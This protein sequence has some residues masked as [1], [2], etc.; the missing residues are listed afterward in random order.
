MIE[1]YAAVFDAMR[2]REYGTG[3]P[4]NGSKW[5]RRVEREYRKMSNSA[6]A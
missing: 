1:D 3:N 5:A 4:I 2:K 6:C